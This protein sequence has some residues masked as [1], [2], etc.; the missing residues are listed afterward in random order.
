MIG[1]MEDF[2]FLFGV[3]T[4][5]VIA[6][7]WPFVWRKVTAQPAT[8]PKAE[9]S[10][11]AETPPAEV[12]PLSVRLH[13]RSQ[14][15][16]YFGDRTAHPRELSDRSEFTE[17][18]A[19]LCDSDVKVDVVAQYALGA[20]WTLSCAAL[21]ALA[22]RADG[23]RVLHE[24]VAAFGRLRPWAMHFALAYFAALTNRPAAGAPA[25]S[26]DHWWQDNLVIPGLF[27]SYFTKVQ[28]L[29]DKPVFGQSATAS[30]ASD[31]ATIEN[32]L[33]S[34]DHPFA[35][36]LID[37][38][39]SVRSARIDTSFLEGF[40]RFWSRTSDLDVLLVPDEW[41]DLLAAAENTVTQARARSLIIRGDP[42]V[43]KSSFLKLLGDRL[44]RKGWTIFEAGG[45]ELQA[46]Q[47]YIGQL[48]ERVRRMAGELSAAKR[49][50]WY[51]PD[52]LQI[53][54]SGTHHGQ[55]ASNLDQVLPAVSA[56]RLIIVSEATPTQTTQLVQLRPNLK[57]L[58]EVAPLNAMAEDRAL[59]FVQSFLER[60]THKSRVTF[61]SGSAQL[62]MLLARQ[63][64]GTSQLPG[65]VLDLLKL[66]FNRCV[67]E[68]LKRIAPRDILVT[69][70]QATGLPLSILDSK[71]KVELA[72][73]QRFFGEQVMGQP[74]AVHTVVDRIAMLKAGLTDPT[75]PI[76]VF[77]FAGP[78]GTGK[79]ELAKT[80]AAF[81]FGS[82]ER[83]IRL[84]M[85]ELKTPESLNK[86]LGEPGTAQASEALINKVRK[87]PFSVV[88][89]D[90]FE[91]AHANVWDLFL[92]VFDDGRLSDATGNVAD[93]RHCIII[94]TSNL[95]ATA[96][97]SVGLGF[98]AKAD[99]FSSDQIM[100][101][102]GQAFR[103][104]F[105]N[106]L[107]GVIVFQPLKRELMKQ[108]LQKEL[109]QVLERRGLRNREWAVEWESSALEFLL[110]KGFSPE[111]GARPLKRAID[112]CWPRLLQRS[113]S[114][115]SPRG[116]NSYSC[117]ATAGASRS[118][119]S[120]PTS[121][122]APRPAGPRRRMASARCSPNSC[123]AQR[124]PRPSE[125]RSKRRSAPSR[126]GS[127]GPNGRNSRNSSRSG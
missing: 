7:T 30:F 2:I 77:L 72:D 54:V 120:I 82:A 15:L 119:S 122:R 67:G 95:G 76:G 11:L 31:P 4:G 49:A 43:G 86:I 5:V 32:F 116:T 37:E 12:E 23:E 17:A 121:I 16:E 80:L 45:P 29:G 25:A 1:G 73:V 53:A 64:L 9:T 44:L 18:V 26:A 28:E 57:G 61:D 84:D 66:T 75:K 118:S 127:K 101:A 112:M 114:I 69:L 40:G 34:L 88:L 91:K 39:R 70:S 10:A 81:L 63:Y 124:A 115:A 36:A 79:T 68:G 123:L 51:V 48:E 35:T 97:H 117:A 21:E 90:E 99:A 92:Q 104:E 74:E 27:R 100:R 71:E 78:T 102:I 22:K 62:A 59:E 52:V 107:D 38:L 55:S 60:L 87:Q 103:P 8:Q 41:K 46:G 47:A 94:L 106:R 19:M 42:K 96:H 113:S 50:L 20:N 105:I 13:G 58:F 93:F 125:P 56:A 109:R 6:L 126:N 108:I 85:S 14:T 110:D 83:L 65:A 98:G 24:I 33:K 3:A 89:L 111:L